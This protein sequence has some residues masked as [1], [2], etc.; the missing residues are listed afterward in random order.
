LRLRVVDRRVVQPDV[1]LDVTAE[2]DGS[3]ISDLDVAGAKEVAAV[4]HLNERVQDR[5]PK[6][7]G[8]GRKVEGVPVENLSS[9]L[10]SAVD[11]HER[12]VLDGAP[13]AD[14]DRCQRQRG[15][16]GSSGEECHDQPDAA[17][18]GPEPASNPRM[19]LAHTASGRKRHLWGA[20]G[21]PGNSQRSRSR[22]SPLY[23]RAG[24]A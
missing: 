24:S 1:G 10:Q 14:V 22:A 21:S 8:I 23:G 3:A 2:H 11:S 19:Q 20:R 12:P 18:D 9:G 16:R 15:A 4:R 13:L 7:L 5:I 17:H 6:A